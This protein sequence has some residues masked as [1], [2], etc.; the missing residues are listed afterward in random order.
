MSLSTQSSFFPLSSPLLTISPIDY[1][2]QSTEKSGVLKIREKECVI[3]L[4]VHKIPHWS[5]IFSRLYF[6]ITSFFFTRV[7]YEG[8]Y[9]YIL[10][11]VKKLGVSSIET[12]RVEKVLSVARNALALLENDAA[13]YLPALP[14]QVAEGQAS[15]CEEDNQ[16]QPILEKTGFSNHT[17]L[18]EFFNREEIKKYKRDHLKKAIALTN[19]FNLTETA[20]KHPDGFALLKKKYVMPLLAKNTNEVVS[21]PTMAAFKSADDEAVN[22]YA[23]TGDIAIGTSKRVKLLLP[24]LSQ[25]KALTEAVP[26]GHS[27]ETF[28]QEYAMSR[29][30]HESQAP[31]FLKLHKVSWNGKVRL[32]SELCEMGSIHNVWN[33]GLHTEY[34]MKERLTLAF[35]LTQAL[36][37]LHSQTKMCHLD[38][39]TNNLFIKMV[40]GKPELRVGDFGSVRGI[41]PAIRIGLT[42][43][44]PPP[45]MT[46]HTAIPIHPSI[47]LW[48]LGIILY[49]LKYGK[50]EICPEVY[51]LA[52]HMRDTPQGKNA[53]FQISCVGNDNPD[54]IDLVIRS[55]LNTDPGKRPTAECVMNILQKYL[56]KCT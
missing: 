54:G 25:G 26:Y 53:L 33:K 2:I 30:I 14:F 3:R 27:L 13:E 38:L 23:V 35:Q 16:V 15:S 18:D 20:K 36:Q 40:D 9:I 11:D 43:T 45:E 42:A 49:Q 6:W 21:V 55:L 19:F 32:L 12:L 8:S 28:E 41:S 17:D 46:S 31:Y 39:K 56:E 22:V 47:D 44:F 48:A 1:S 52:H 5:D 51:Y 7:E 10:D 24:L 50:S 37:H 4:D 34:T 29:K